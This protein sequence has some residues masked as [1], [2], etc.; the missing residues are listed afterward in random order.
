M[1][2]EPCEKCR[3]RE[4]TVHLTLIG[5]SAEISKHHFC[6]SCYAGAQEERAKTFS[7][8]VEQAVTPPT[9]TTKEITSVK[10]PEIGGIKSKKREF[11]TGLWTQCKQC[12]ALVFNQELAQNLKVCPHCQFHFPMGARERV[13]SLASSFTELN[14][15]MT[16]LDVLNFTSPE[17]YKSKLAD[18]QKSAGQ[19]DA[20]ITGIGNI[21]EH[22]VGLGVLDFGFLGGSMGSVVGEK[23][24]RLI[25]K[26]TEKALPVIIISASGGAR[27]Y[28]GMY[29]LMQMA[30][31]C[32]ALARHSQAKLPYISV[33][34]DPTMGGVLAS[35][36]GVGGLIIAEPGARIGL[37]GAQVIKDTLHTELPAGFQTAEFLLGRGLIDAIV[38]RKEMKN[39]LIQYLDF[40]TNELNRAVERG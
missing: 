32:G 36:A 3:Q 33:L 39:R 37:T 6:E 40:M 7:E 25:E 9:P 5:L 27:I 8:T 1:K 31:T 11:P 28:E 22:G 15:D 20:V 17:T 19:Q 29:S 18:Y 10:K 16:S 21:G 2:V 30:K 12:A 26:S 24:T 38:S 34:T 23:L 13:H 4:A 35:F 14:T